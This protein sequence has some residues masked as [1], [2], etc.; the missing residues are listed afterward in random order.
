[1][2]RRAL[3]PNRMHRRTTLDLP[4]VSYGASLEGCPLHW[5]PPRSKN[6]DLL[7][8]AGL[9]GEE[10]DTTVIL[11]RACRSLPP[12]DIAPDVGIILSA[13]PDGLAAGTRGN[14]RGVDL[15]R[16]FPA[17]NWSADEST[18]RWHVEDSDGLPIG[19]GA[20]PS[21]EPEVAALIKLIEAHA[22]QRILS[23]HGPLDCVDDPRESE[24]GLWIASE[25]GSPLVTDIGYPTPG[26]MGSWA[27]ERCLPIVTWEFPAAGI[28]ELSRRF[29]PLLGEILRSGFRNLPS[30]DSD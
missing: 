28:E 20:S 21:S 26:S 15:N 25:T 13:N 6:C 27:W 11:S 9:H 12:S 29:V 30:P 8:I 17:S 24:L 3:T 10:P 2:I 7:L 19:T 23:L 18:A 1:M 22:P 16:N 4:L 5:I 14:A